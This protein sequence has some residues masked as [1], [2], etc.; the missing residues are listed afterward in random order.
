M[1]VRGFDPDPLN[2]NNGQAFERLQRMVRTMTEQICK[3]LSRLNP[4]FKSALMGKKLTLK[5]LV[6]KFTKN[7]SDL[8]LFGRK[9]THIIVQS[10]SISSS[11]RNFI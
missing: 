9:H 4:R 5:A 8:F 10:V 11:E 7:V 3:L 2:S 1:S 6:R